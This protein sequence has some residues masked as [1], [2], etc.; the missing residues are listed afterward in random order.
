MSLNY[1]QF[2]IVFAYLVSSISSKSVKNITNMPTPSVESNEMESPSSVE[3]STIMISLLNPKTTTVI[4]KLDQ[5][6][7]LKRQ[8]QPGPASRDLDAGESAKSHHWGGHGHAW[9]GHGG[10]GYGGGYGPG[11]GGGYGP[12]YG[13]HGYYG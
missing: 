11:Y 4:S 12:G 1:F 6:S 10:P 8:S 2:L 7:S 13:G 3:T 9:G 5:S